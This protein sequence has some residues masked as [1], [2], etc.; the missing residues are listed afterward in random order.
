MNTDTLAPG[1]IHTLS[2][3]AL[4]ALVAHLRDRVARR[5]RAW[6]TLRHAADDAAS[7]VVLHV[8]ERLRTLPTLPANLGAWLTTVVE[9]RL[10]DLHRKARRVR[11]WELP[12]HDEQEVERAVELR[13]HANPERALDGKRAL[14]RFERL[15]VSYAEREGG[16]GAQL[17]A[18]YATRFLERSAGEVAAELE[19]RTAKRVSPALVWKWSERGRARLLALADSDPCRD[20]GAWMRLVVEGLDPRR[21]LSVHA[22]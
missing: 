14:A 19:R 11:E 21:E 9:H 20:D 3:D 22:R 17:D 8:L 6:A 16:R 4:A 13:P 1:S 7:D 15:L 12:A 10:T 18:W 2:A 5:A